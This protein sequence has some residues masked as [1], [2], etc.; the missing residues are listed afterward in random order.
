MTYRI[1]L[2]ALEPWFFGSDRKFPFKG[3]PSS[4]TDYFIRSQDT[5]SQSA[6]FGVLRYL[7]ILGKK[8][9][10]EVQEEFIGKESFRLDSPIRPIGQLFGKIHSI[11]PL[12]L[13]DG[14]TYYIPAPMLTDANPEHY[15][16]KNPEKRAKEGW[17]ALDS[18]KPMIQDGMDLP[19][20]PFK[21]K[22]Q[23]GRGS[24]EGQLFKREYKYFEN[25][26]M[27]FAFFA[28]CDI[29][30]SQSVVHMG[31]GKCPFLASVHRCDAP[32]PKNKTKLA[33]AQSDIFV[34]D[35]E[36]LYDCCEYF[37]ARQRNQRVLT[38]TKLGAKLGLD[39]LHTIQAG[40]VF[41][42]K[43]RS[44]FENL[45]QGNATIAGYNKVIF[46]EETTE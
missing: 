42:V 41:C 14:E 19:K 13:F 38:H 46:G 31:Q 26:N 9:D 6:L 18:K 45:L 16:E 7:V 32:S 12:Y 17:I 28:D 5:P 25:P 23:F 37:A 44:A 4:E 30:P 43:N 11:S 15:D 8:I 3:S 2:E 10:S 20:N 40:S 22:E 36:A 24:G 35:T 29:E 1:T 21:G 33:Y 27:R 34:S 39:L